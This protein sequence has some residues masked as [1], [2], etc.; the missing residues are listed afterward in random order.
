M[1]RLCWIF[2]ALFGTT[3][4]ITP[5]PQAKQHKVSLSESASPYLLESSF[6]LAEDDTLEIG[7]GV[8]VFFGG[9]AK[10]YLRGTVRIAGLA[11]RPV[12]FLSADSSESW[13]GIYFSTGKNYF[14]I[15]NLRVENAFRNTVVRSQGILDGVSF[16]NNY[17]GL[18]V[19]NSPHLELVNCDFSRNRFALSVGVG[20]VKFR[21]TKIRENVF[22]LYLYRGTSFDGSAESVSGN[23][24]ADIRRESDEQGRSIPWQRIESGF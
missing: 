1:K 2:L 16:V 23:L 3:F 18:W 12:I 4:A 13:N 17:Y 10:L 20:S 22:G 14:E 19:E 15:R 8:E 7:P 6:I 21:K 5:F 24:Q 11:K 9:Y